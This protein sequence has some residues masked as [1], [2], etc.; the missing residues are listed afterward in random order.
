M[1]S[2]TEVATALGT[3]NTTAPVTTGSL[4]WQHAMLQSIAAFR[5][6][7]SQP[8][9]GESFAGLVSREFFFGSCPCS[10][11]IAPSQQPT[12][13]ACKAEAHAGAHKSITATKHTHA[14]NLLPGALESWR[15]LSVFPNL[16]NTPPHTLS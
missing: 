12:P 2:G 1:R 11:H 14:I 7:C 4:G 8:A 16:N 10:G 9:M 3:T 6:W 15:I 5:A 13:A